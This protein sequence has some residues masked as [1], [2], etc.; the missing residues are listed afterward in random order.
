MKG[1]VGNIE[2][3]TLQ[4]EN[5]LKV[6]YTGP[7]SQLTV[8]CIQ[9]GDDIGDEMHSH[10]QFTRVESGSARVI[11]DGE[12]ATIGADE[13]V[14]IP[15]GAHHNIVNASSTET[16]KLYTVYSMPDHVDGAVYATKADLAAAEGGEHVP[17]AVA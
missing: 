8:M 7:K 15:M 14:I 17:Q 5:F 9:A 11:I 16:L 3:E 10:D 6:L 1:Y 12:E 2:T 4:N 13:A